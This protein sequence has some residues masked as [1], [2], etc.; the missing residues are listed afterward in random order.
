[1]HEQRV[2]RDPVQEGR[3]PAVGRQQVDPREHPHQVVDPEREDQPEQHEAPPAP[4]VARGVV[5]DRVADHERQRERDRDEHERPDEDREELLALPEVAQ[6]LDEVAGVPVERV[7][8]RDRLAEGVL[9]AEGDAQHRVQRDEEEDREPGDARKGER[10]PEPARL[11]QPALNFDQAFSQSRSPSV[12]S[13]SSSWFAANWSGRTSAP[14]SD[15]G[16]SF[17][18]IS[19]SASIAFWG[20]V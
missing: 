12:V 9:V 20:G 14:R 18:E 17:F 6:R 13:E 3:A 7:P 8:V 11:H 5:G 2:E 15:S 19:E 4:G 10:A 16:I 1:M